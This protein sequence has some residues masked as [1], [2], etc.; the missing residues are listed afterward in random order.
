MEMLRSPTLACFENQEKL[1]C[2]RVIVC[3]RTR[4]PFHWLNR[5]AYIKMGISA[6]CQFPSVVHVYT[7]GYDAVDLPSVYQL[8]FSQSVLLVIM[9]A[10]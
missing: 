7:R 10:N 5:Y 9:S 2:P 6:S 1:L 8:C 4:A 3:P